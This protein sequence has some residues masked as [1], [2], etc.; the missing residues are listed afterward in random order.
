MAFTGDI[1]LTRSELELV[2][3]SAVFQEYRVRT[4]TKTPW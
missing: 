4:A 1:L 2:G 3:R